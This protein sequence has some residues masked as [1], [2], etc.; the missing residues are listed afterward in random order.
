MQ[1][2]K[3]TAVTARTQKLHQVTK[4]NLLGGNTKGE[5]KNVKLWSYRT[6]KSER[7]DWGGWMGEQ[8]KIKNIDFF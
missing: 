6:I 4:N 1:L 2:C 3:T 5:D 8:N 7:G